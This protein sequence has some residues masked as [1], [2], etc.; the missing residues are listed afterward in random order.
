MKICNLT[1]MVALSLALPTSA[2]LANMPVSTSYGFAKFSDQFC[3]ANRSLEQIFVLPIEIFATNSKISCDFG[4]STLR[5]S[6][7]Q[8][9]PAHYILNID[10]PQNVADGLDCD[11]KANINMSIVALN[12]LPANREKIGNKRP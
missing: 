9:D 4:A 12:C 11:S 8:R 3:G 5:L 10:P 1:A 6:K 2:A 7:S